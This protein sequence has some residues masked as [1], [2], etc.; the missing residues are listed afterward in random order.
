[1][2]STIIVLGYIFLRIKMSKIYH[3]TSSLGLLGIIRDG[4][5]RCTNLKYLNDKL[6]H[7]HAIDFFYEECDRLKENAID[8]TPFKK[9]YTTLAS[10]I[11]KNIKD[12]YVA[13]FTEK[14]DN[15]IHWLSYGRN[16]VNYS[17]EFDKDDLVYASNVCGRKDF[18][19]DAEFFL[20]KRKDNEVVSGEILLKHFIPRFECVKYNLDAIRELLSEDGVKKFGVQGNS[21]FALSIYNELCFLFPSI[22]TEEW[23]EEK[24]WRIILS[25]RS[26]IDR[27]TG[28]YTHN[29][30]KERLMQW[31]ENNG[32]LIP[33]VDFP[34]NRNIIKK[35][36]YHSREKNERIEDSLSLLKRIY[37]LDFEIKKSESSYY[38]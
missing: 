31:R 10:F 38:R 2:K 23:K 1:M 16:D 36:T 7:V 3:Y 9:L 13:C 28:E 20:G 22:K 35:I 19:E 6:E 29:P 33:F 12:T 8:G 27:V 18:K 25:E 17:V 30:E 26:S 37:N 24:E 5:I 32:L 34:I 14:E 21:M 11:Q 15:T 4:A